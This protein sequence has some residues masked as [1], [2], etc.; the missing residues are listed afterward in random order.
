MAADPVVLSCSAAQIAP[1]V[2]LIPTWVRRHPNGLLGPTRPDL[3]FMGLVFQQRHLDVGCSLR[4][5]L[6]VRSDGG[7]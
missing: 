1:C 2:L 4:F 6:G 5:R 3:V 7:Y